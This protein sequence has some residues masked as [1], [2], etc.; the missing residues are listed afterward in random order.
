[1][2]GNGYYVVS[3]DPELMQ[4]AET[5][6]GSDPHA[7]TLLSWIRMRREDNRPEGIQ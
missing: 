2:N 3:A 6:V 7:L 5:A 4:L 1:M